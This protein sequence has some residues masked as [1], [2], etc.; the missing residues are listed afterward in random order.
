MMK[1]RKKDKHELTNWEKTTINLKQALKRLK[2]NL[3]LLKLTMPK[4]WS[5]MSVHSQILQMFK[6]NFISQIKPD[7]KMKF[8]L[9]KKLKRIKD[10]KKWSKSK[11]NPLI[12]EQRKLKIWISNWLILNV[13]LKN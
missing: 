3:V 13:K 12:T 7:M 8:V 10:C 6:K 5:S 2:L 9:L 4:S 11:K 1:C